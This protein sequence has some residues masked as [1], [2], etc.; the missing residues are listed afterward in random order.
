MKP[1]GKVALL[2]RGDRAARDAATAGTSR[3]NRVFEA[4][5]QA[6]VSAEPAVFDEAML[7]EVRDQLLAVDGVLVWVDPL[8]DGRTRKLLDPLLREVSQ[9]GPWVSTHPDVIAKMGTKEVL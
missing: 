8:S 2:W 7:D 5:A 6:G 4:L 9:Q 3:F 1:N